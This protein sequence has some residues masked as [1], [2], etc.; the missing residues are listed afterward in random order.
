MAL[1]YCS[2]SKF[3]RRSRRFDIIDCVLL[4]YQKEQG[5][6]YPFYLYKKILGRLLLDVLQIWPPGVM[7]LLIVI[8]VFF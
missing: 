2:L 3:D 8:S 7:Y 4:K 6:L 1:F 5:W